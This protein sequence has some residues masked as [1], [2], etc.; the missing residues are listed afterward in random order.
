MSHCSV[1]RVVQW[2]TKNVLCHHSPL[3]NKPIRNMVTERQNHR[4]YKKKRK[5]KEKENQTQIALISIE[6]EC[7][8]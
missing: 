2:I 5:K 6:E 1:A 8:S 3:W 4:K 7:L